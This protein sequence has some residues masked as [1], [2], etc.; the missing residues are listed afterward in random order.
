MARYPQT[1]WQGSDDRHSTTVQARATRAA[2]PEAGSTV[3]EAIADFLAAAEN[4]SALDRYGR[5]FSDE[6]VHELRWCLSSHVDRRL[7][8]LALTEVRRRDIE[9]L[10]AD[11]DAAGLSRSRVRSVAKSVRALYDYARE[12]GLVEDNPAERI[13]LPDEDDARQPS[14]D[15][16]PATGIRALLAGSDR[17]LDGADRALA[18]F[19]HVATVCFVLF[20]LVLIAE[21][22]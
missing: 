9:A 19:L 5:A 10:V 4:G 13:A 15:R 16:P 3:H 1:A 8:A 2:R 7:G 11:L 12:R 6:S 18:L 20:A 22:L 21:S 17:A 14:R